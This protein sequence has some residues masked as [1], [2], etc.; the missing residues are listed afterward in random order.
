MDFGAEMN[1]VVVTRRL[2]AASDVVAAEENMKEK[3]LQ[4]LLAAFALTIVVGQEYSVLTLIG[5]LEVT[6]TIGGS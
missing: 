5:H 3:L 1:P 2:V 6:Q 4:A